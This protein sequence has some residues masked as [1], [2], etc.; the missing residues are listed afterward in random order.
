MHLTVAA[1][2]FPSRMH[3]GPCAESLRTIARTRLGWHRRVPGGGCPSHA[4]SAN[5]TR[6]NFIEKNGLQSVV[7]VFT[8]CPRRWAFERSKRSLTLTPSGGA[9]AATYQP[10]EYS[11]DRV[12]P[13]PR[14]AGEL[15]V[16]VV[17]PAP[18]VPRPPT[19]PLRAGAAMTWLLRSTR[20][21]CAS[22]SRMGTKRSAVT[23]DSSTSF[24]ALRSVSCGACPRKSFTRIACWR[25]SV[26][27]MGEF[28]MITT[29]SMSRPSRR[30]SF[31]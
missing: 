30:R 27:D 28:S 13:N 17:A 10:R 16:D 22:H 12:A 1:R 24:T 18:V 8:A 2:C 25:L 15:A 21:C 11:G 20:G 6:C 14:R 29:R 23:H 9:R 31:V 26:T 4:Q 19:M 7:W 3:L 5:K